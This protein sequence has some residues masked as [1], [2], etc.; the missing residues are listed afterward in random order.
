MPANLKER[1]KKHC[2]DWEIREWNS[3]AAKLL[4]Y[5]F[6][7]EAFV[8]GKWGFVADI[9]RL[10]SVAT[11]GGVYLD[12]DVE[13]LRPLDPLLKHRFFI[14]VEKYRRM[15]AL[16]AHMFGAIPNHTIITDVLSYYSKR[17]FINEDGSLNQQIIPPKIT[18]IVQRRYILPNLS[19]IEEPYELAD[20]AFI[21]PVWSF[22]NLE[23]G[24]QSYGVHKYVGSWHNGIDNV[25][26]SVLNN[27]SIPKGTDT[28]AKLD[29]L[30]NCSTSHPVTPPLSGYPR[31][32]KVTIALIMISLLIRFFFKRN[33]AHRST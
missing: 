29:Q 23:E 2:P 3:E 6:L 28:K 11:Y 1:R 12:S 5:S 13:I 17:H 19:E 15:V 4:P 20:N 22:C 7:H 32:F 25:D 24:K 33:K 30:F 16:G 21:Y 9:I 10:Y 31:Y 18:R 8:T 14:G 26:P 27:I